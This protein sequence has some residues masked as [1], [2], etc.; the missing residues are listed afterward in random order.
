MGGSLASENNGHTSD[1]FNLSLETRWPKL[2][3]SMVGGELEQVKG[4]PGIIFAGLVLLNSQ[5]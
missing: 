5:G 1:A 3:P 4:N 2:S